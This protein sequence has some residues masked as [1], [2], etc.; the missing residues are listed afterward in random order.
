MYP[1]TSYLLTLYYMRKLIYSTSCL[2]GQLLS[3]HKLFIGQGNY[4]RQ[5][6]K[7]RFDALKGRWKR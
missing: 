7:L 4:V 5:V 3:V 2:A 6:L 1:Y